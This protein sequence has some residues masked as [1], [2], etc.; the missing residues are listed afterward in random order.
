MPTIPR[1]KEWLDLCSISYK[2]KKLKVEF[3]QLLRDNGMESYLTD[4]NNEKPLYRTVTKT[5]IIKCSLSHA[6]NLDSDTQKMCIDRI[7]EYVNILSRMMRRASLAL[8]YHMKRLVEKNLPLPDLYKS[9]GGDEM[10]TYWKKWLE[11]GCYEGRFPNDNVTRGR[12]A[13]DKEVE[14]SYKSIP[15]MGLVYAT[16]TVGYVENQ[17][18]GFD[19]VLA[20]AAKTFATIVTNDAWC[21]LFDRL[22]RLTRAMVEEYPNIYESQVTKVIRFPQDI[23]EEWPEKVREYVIEVRTGLGLGEDDILW[24]N[25]FFIYRMRI[26]QS[27]ALARPTVQ[28]TFVKKVEKGRSPFSSGSKIPFEKMFMFNVW[29][30][31]KFEGMEKRGMKL[32]PICNVH[33]M[34]V[35][36]DFKTLY[37]LSMEILPKDD[38]AKKAVKKHENPYLGTKDEAYTK[39][40]DTNHNMFPIGKN[41]KTDDEVRAIKKTK[42][43]LDWKDFYD[44][45]VTYQTYLKNPDNSK[46]FF[47][48]FD[49]KDWKMRDHG[50]SIKSQEWIDH[51][52]R[53][54]AWEKQ[55]DITKKSEAYLYH[56][57]I[58]ETYL[59]LK[60]KLV[61][62]IFSDFTK[63]KWASKG[64]EFDSSILTDGVAVSLQYSKTVQIKIDGKRPTPPAEKAKFE[65]TPYDL[66]Q[67][68]QYNDDTLILGMDPG[69]TNLVTVCYLTKDGKTGSWK[70]TRGRYYEE[71]GLNH[72]ARKRRRNYAHLIPFWTELSTVGGCLKSSKSADILKYIEVYA[73]FEDEWWNMALKRSESQD[74]FQTYSRKRQVLDGFF[75]RIKKEAMKLPGIKNIIAA[76]GSAHINPT[77]KGEVAAPGRKGGFAPFST[78]FCRFL[79]YSARLRRADIG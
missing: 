21:P 68:T 2:G 60:H 53:E 46:I 48:P 40:P 4:G 43:Y 28:S 64:W 7:D 9:V 1:M 13:Y 57:H 18:K 34:H 35:R 49:E 38:V 30:Q 45:F 67:T 63:T 47:P 5:R 19:Q 33:R 61:Q 79:P 31:K 76:Y 10:L 51:K 12:K 58:Y 14:I 75:S 52:A 6:L 69:R 15:D 25:S 78:F 23:P 50:K 77:G 8:S 44:K 55:K 32:I 65:K 37:N 26:L 24:K 16:D 71:S 27:G 29:M 22:D 17:P 70:L 62:S 41:K 39:N 66:N 36:L 54:T 42:K 56:K 3:E 73:Q 74:K 72:N 59:Q 20:Y 11:I